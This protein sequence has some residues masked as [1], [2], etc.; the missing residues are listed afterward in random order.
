MTALIV[1][2]LSAFVFLLFFHSTLGLR[3]EATPLL[4]AESTRELDTLPVTCKSEIKTINA[5]PLDVESLDVDTY[6]IMMY[7][8]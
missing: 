8:D 2:F 3:F 4:S 7:E 5:R 6:S 1:Y